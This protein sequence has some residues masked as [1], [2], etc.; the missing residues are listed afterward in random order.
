MPSQDLHRTALTNAVHTEPP[1]SIVGGAAVAA[2]R[3]T[4][5]E[6]IGHLRLFPPHLQVWVADPGNVEGYVPLDGSVYRGGDGVPSA[7]DPAEF[8]VLGTAP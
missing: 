6:L 1:P 4:V 3:V 8:L 7:A 2:E 5:A